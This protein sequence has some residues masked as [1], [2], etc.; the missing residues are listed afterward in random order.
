MVESPEK[1][2][3]SSSAKR[4]MPKG[5]MPDYYRGSSKNVSEG[6]DLK[7]KSCSVIDP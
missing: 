3:R 5:S 2:V 4:P 1:E 7:G 6:S